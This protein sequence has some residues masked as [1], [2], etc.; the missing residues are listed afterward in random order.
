MHIY[1]VFCVCYLISISSSS[2][3]LSCVFV[4]GKLLSMGYGFVQYKTP[5]AAQKAMRQL[6]VNDHLP[7]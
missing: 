4:S 2:L 1:N 5:E 7:V 3:Y 6:Q